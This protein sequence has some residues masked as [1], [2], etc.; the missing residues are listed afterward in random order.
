MFM[1]FDPIFKIGMT[2]AATGLFV[3]VGGAALLAI[4][5]HEPSITPL[6]ATGIAVT[7]AGFLTA[8]FIAIVDM[9]RH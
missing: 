7:F 9:W 8:I 4:S 3:M 2:L 5:G 6:I 1:P